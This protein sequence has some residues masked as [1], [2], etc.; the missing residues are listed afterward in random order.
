MLRSQA[1]E[2]GLAVEEARAKLAPFLLAPLL[3]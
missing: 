2:L 1:G 3:Q